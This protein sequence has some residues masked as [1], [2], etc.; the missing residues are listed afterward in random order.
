MSIYWFYVIGNLSAVVCILAFVI[1]FAFVVS[2]LYILF[3]D[4]G[5]GEDA[6]NK[7]AGHKKICKRIG[8]VSL[9]LLV[10]SIFAVSSDNLMKIYVVDNVVEY[11]ENNDKAQSLPHKVIECCDKLMNEYLEDKEE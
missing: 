4:Y 8:V 6:K 2:L 11:I 10:A 3:N 5:Y 7:R 1:V 9:V